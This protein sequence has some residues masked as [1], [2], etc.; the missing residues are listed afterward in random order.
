MTAAATIDPA[1]ASR[2]D[3]PEKPPPAL[4][5]V[6]SKGNVMASA[7]S[8]DGLMKWLDHDNW[9]EFLLAVVDQH[10]A[11]CEAHDV[12]REELEPIL[13][14]A[15]VAN[16]WG[17]AFED[18]LTRSDLAGRNI[19][20]D[21][22]KRRGWKETPT[23]RRYI[24]ALR[25]SVMSL[26][27]VSGVVPGESFLAR[28][29]VRG[30]EPTRVFERSGSKTMKEWDR[31][32]VRLVDMG[33][34]TEMAGGVLAFDRETGDELLAALKKFAAKLPDPRKEIAAEFG[35]DTDDPAVAK[36]L[37]VSALLRDAAPLITNLWLSNFLHRALNPQPPT[38][39]NSDGDDIVMV[40]VRYPLAP[41]VKR[42]QVRAAL[43]TIGSLSPS[44]KTFWNWI[45]TAPP[46]SARM[47]RGK[48]D[49]PTISTTLD[50]GSIV[51]G[52]VELKGKHVVLAANSIERSETGRAM[53]EPALARL[54]K[55]P[56][57]EFQ[58]PE[59]L[60]AARS[61][62]KPARSLDLPPEEIRRIVHA[63]LDQMYRQQ[64]D[65]PVPMLGDVS[66]RKAVR[67]KAGRDKVVAWLKTLENHM[68]HVRPDDSMAGYE[69]LWL[70]EE[71]GVADRRC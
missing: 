60:M 39:S 42:E 32:G 29:L 36:E 63:K 2:N 20:D 53:L 7:K 24:T 26:Y 35:V 54:V 46:K 38:F 51:L 62:K 28:D 48:I 19:V 43:E 49:A 71:L 21:Y 18:F 50:D 56:T 33:A 13:G 59:E 22:L 15:G 47:K 64:L 4:I 66:P 55:E 44:S 27:E 34:R 31:I 16:L 67:S 40:T 3:P 12:E 9:R 1:S 45:R 23:N 58:T 11:A 65:E 61:G 10:L 57:V 5:P 17:C 69:I 6:A 25:H 41:G 8:L 37:S 52:A 14:E 30:G 68:S 70:W